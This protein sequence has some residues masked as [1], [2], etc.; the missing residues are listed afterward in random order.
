MWSISVFSSVS[1]ITFA[2]DHALM[3]FKWASRFWMTL[4]LSLCSRRAYIH[5]TG[6]HLRTWHGKLHNWWH[7]TAVKNIGWTQWSWTQWA[8]T[9]ENISLKRVTGWYRESAKLPYPCW[10]V[11]IYLCHV[12]KLSK[13]GSPPKMSHDMHR[14][15]AGFHWN[16]Y[17]IIKCPQQS[18]LASLKDQ[19]LVPPHTVHIIIASLVKWINCGSQLT[20]APVLMHGGNLG[21]SIGY[22]W[23]FAI[24]CSA[25]LPV[26]YTGFLQ[27]VQSN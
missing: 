10:L 23:K 6:C 1:F 14:I 21:T 7:P 9:L 27:E 13:L 19:A 2:E 20:A 16:C 18:H 11:D 22:Y 25:H 8:W 12:N 17:L 5:V 15:M 24:Y 3:S 4:D 26:I